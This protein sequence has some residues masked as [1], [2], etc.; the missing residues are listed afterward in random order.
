VVVDERATL[1]RHED[2]FSATADNAVKAFLADP[3]VEREVASK[4]SA[5]WGI[6]KEIVDKGQ[7]RA[8]VGQEE[9]T[10]EQQQDETRRNLKAIEKNKAAEAL[11]AKLTQRLAEVAGRVDELTKQAVELDAKLAE[12]RV[13]FKETVRD[14]KWIAAPKPEA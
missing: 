4:I 12:L 3:K 2:W 6:R 11:R 14:V 9:S 1:T 7:A 13:L 5:A 8:K 10:L